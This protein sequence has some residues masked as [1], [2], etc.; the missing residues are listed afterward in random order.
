MINP[1][2]SVTADSD[3]RLILPKD[4]VRELGLKPGGELLLRATPDGLLIRPPLSQLRKVYIEPTNRCNLACRTCIRNAWDEPMGSMSIET[5]ERILSGLSELEPRPSMF[6]GG[7]GEPLMHPSIGRMVHEA[8]QV[9][10][11]VE[12]ITNGLLLDP[13]L[14]AQ[15]IESGLSTLWVS[16]DGA[17]PES[18]A[19][20]R[21][22]NSLSG[23]LQNIATYREL[24]RRLHGDEADIGVIFVAMKRNINELPAL[25]RQST[26]L[27]I[28]RYMLTN[29]LPYTAEMCD[30]VLYHHSVDRMNGNPS[31]WNPGIHLPEIDLNP[32]TREALFKIWTARPGG[33]TER[34]DRCP[35]MEQ[36][37]I[38]V[39][40]EG[41][42]SPCLAL[43][44][45]HESYLF[46]IKRSVRRYSLGD[47]NERPLMEVWLSDEYTQFRQKV[48]Q[49]DFPP[50]AVCASCENAEANQEDCFGNNFPTCGGCLWAK[51][52]IQCP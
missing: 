22:S 33:L 31:P 35:F 48:E 12:L 36:R 19:D 5:F 7:F 42:V 24:Y 10:D 38:S 25:I 49:F 16:L 37:S 32:I 2:S 28:S 23:V 47:V 21:L 51:G 46:D 29:I 40:W 4:F 20:V 1:P 50:C 18:Y 34:Q 52:V 27:G 45:S 39:G 30:E 43:L 13:A 11:R 9:A 8:G 41:S 26:R 6:F 3:G 17:S 44:H 15:L 14:A